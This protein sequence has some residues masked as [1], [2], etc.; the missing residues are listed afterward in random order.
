MF[1]PKDASL[2]KQADIH[3]GPNLEWVDS[4]LLG[5]KTDGQHKG[6]TF[7]IWS[8]SVSKL[9]PVLALYEHMQRTSGRELVFG[10][11]PEQISTI[12]KSV[13]KDA[14]VDA[15]IFT[16]RTFRSGGD[17][18]THYKIKWTS[19]SKKGS[20]NS[21]TIHFS[22]SSSGSDRG[23]SKL[24][25]QKCVKKLFSVM[26]AQKIK[27]IL[28]TYNIFYDIIVR[29][30]IFQDEDVS[31]FFKEG[32]EWTSQSGMSLDETSYEESVSGSEDE[33]QLEWQDNTLSGGY[34][35]SELVEKSYDSLEWQDSGPCKRGLGYFHGCE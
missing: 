22:I 9:C 3:F 1:R 6:E 16:V 29:K 5:F 28:K 21:R 17:H 20:K 7:C 26:I 18:E 2:L 13:I 14:G 19:F 23:R 15:I 33:N 31:F 30:R 12:L 32:P 35:R 10:V 8:A 24:L 11:S 4:C 34:S 27:V 25:V